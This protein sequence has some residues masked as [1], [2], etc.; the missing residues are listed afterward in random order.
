MWMK[1]ISQQERKESRRLTSRRG[2]E[3]EKQGKERE[4]RKGTLKG[5]WI[6][7]SSS[8]PQNLTYVLPRNLPYHRLYPERSASEDLLKGGVNGRD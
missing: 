5:R 4:R 7:S 1:E 6:D 2:W 3:G 8:E